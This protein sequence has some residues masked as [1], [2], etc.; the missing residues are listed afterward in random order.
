MQ[1]RTMSAVTTASGAP[2]GTPSFDTL[3]QTTIGMDPYRTAV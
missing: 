2:Q 3:F 1:T